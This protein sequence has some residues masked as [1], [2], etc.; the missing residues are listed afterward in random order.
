M[1]QVIDF[2]FFSNVYQNIK[3]ERQLRLFKI[4]DT[5]TCLLN[6]FGRHIF[7]EMNMEL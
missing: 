4:E 6:V 7:I 2:L 3:I 5:G 1:Q